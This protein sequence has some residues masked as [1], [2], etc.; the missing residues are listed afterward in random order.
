MGDGAAARM[1]LAVFGPDAHADF[2]RRQLAWRNLTNERAAGA[3]AKGA[4]AVKDYLVKHGVDGS[5]VQTSGRG[6]ADPVGDNKTEKG[7]FENRRVEVQILS[8]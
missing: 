6:K 8:E 3:F 5:K 2:D 4:E 7:R 1:A